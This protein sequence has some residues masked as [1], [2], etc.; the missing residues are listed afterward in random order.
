MHQEPL[1][2]GDTKGIR[3]RIREK[4]R[5]RWRRR[6][7]LSSASDTEEPETEDEILDVKGEVLEELRT[8]IWRDGSP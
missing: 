8:L 1:P 4:I 6:L 3:V 5:E 2:R 7:C